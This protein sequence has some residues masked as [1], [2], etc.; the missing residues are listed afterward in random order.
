MPDI[1][2]P[3]T[4]LPADRGLRYQQ[5][6]VWREIRRLAR[7]R[8]QSEERGGRGPA[9]GGAARRARSDG[10]G[11]PTLPGGGSQDVSGRR[12]RPRGEP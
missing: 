10:S 3:Q 2:K 4:A 11:P 9:P 5:A 8:D 7:S 1:S 12:V 6:V